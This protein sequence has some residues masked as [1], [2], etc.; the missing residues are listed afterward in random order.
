MDKVIASTAR[1]SCAI[2]LRHYSLSAAEYLTLTPN[3]AD[4]IGEH[5]EML[6]RYPWLHG[7][8]RVPCEAR[9]YTVA[10]LHARPHH[11]GSI[12][13]NN[14]VSVRCDSCMLIT[15]CTDVTLRR[16]WSCPDCRK[17]DKKIRARTTTQT[18]IYFTRPYRLNKL[19]RAHITAEIAQHGTVNGIKVPLKHG[20]MACWLLGCDC[21]ACVAKY[22]LEL[23]KKRDRYRA[24]IST[25]KQ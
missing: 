24:G 5:R 11:N 23:Q 7:K 21:A 2:L 19:E 4:C 16:G 25:R 17:V 13:L 8:Q 12:L 18:G 10:L 15:C 20:T 6:A 3:Y 14:W 22:Q 1:V 9:T